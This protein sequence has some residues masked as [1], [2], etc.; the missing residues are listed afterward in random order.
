MF[1][2]RKKE[3]KLLENICHKKQSS[4]VTI[5]GRRRIGK[6][7]LVDYMFQEYRNDCMFFSYTGDF[8]AN[9]KTQL[10]NFAEA[11][12][13]WFKVDLQIPFKSWTNAFNTLKRV[14]E[15]EA[16]KTN[17]KEKIVIFLDEV[18]WID[19]TN[20]NGFL[21]ALGHFW[22]TYCH[23]K[24]NFIMILCGSNASWIKNK[25]LDD[26]VGPHHKR[27]DEIIELKPFT[28]QETALYLTKE[29][30]LSIDSKIL[31]EIYMIFGGVA[32]YLSLYDANLSLGQNVNKLFFSTNGLLYGEYERVFKSLFQDKSYMYEQIMDFL[33][34][35][36]SGYTAT[37]IAQ[38]LKISPTSPKFRKALDELTIC[39]FIMPKNRVLNEQY[40]STY[41]VADPFCLFY[42]Y[43][44]KSLSLNQ[45]AKL[46][47][48]WDDI[49]SSERYSKW[50]GFSFEM[51]CI[52]NIDLYIKQ[53]GMQG[54]FKNVNYWNYVKDKNSDNEDK[55]TQIDLLVEYKNN[56]YDIVECKYSNKEFVINKTEYEKILNKKAMFIKHGLKNAK[57]DIKIIMLTT[58]GTSK[59]GHY[60][61]V[62]IND[63]VSLEQMFEEFLS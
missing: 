18:P 56:T 43:W 6:T 61:S 36:R 46:I 40:N 3:I 11:I 14:I 42:K 8:E 58:Y 51:V 39:G 44:V 9:N 13:D 52:L 26:G 55:G 63:E 60:D 53:R 17:H 5:Y 7:Y 49:I 32:K 34:S 54:V 59:Q 45:I 20:K 62:P 23:K 48:Y 35:K 10:V 24:G 22:N 21:S 30:K 25:I 16:K 38:N 15:A 37:E 31:T 41:I 33:T 27:V 50:T 19:R 47:N 28:L 2:G 57:H 12:Y 4:L 1:V 29:K